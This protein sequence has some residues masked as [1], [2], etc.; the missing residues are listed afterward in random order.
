YEHGR[1]HPATRTFQALR[2]YVNDELE[3]L[4]IILE[5]LPEIIDKG[6]RVAI[7]SFH[8]LEDRMVKKNFQELVS[9]KKALFINKKPI[10]AGREETNI[11]PKSRSAK[12]RAIKIG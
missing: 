2:I 7:I 6:G 5:K 10:T 12:L 11:N 9:Q 4:K 8:S 1:I 3:N